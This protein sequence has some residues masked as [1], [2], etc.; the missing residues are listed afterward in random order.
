MLRIGEFNAKFCIFSDD[1]I[2][3][4]L[5]KSFDQNHSHDILKIADF[6]YPSSA[7]SKRILKIQKEG[8]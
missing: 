1:E 7:P 8:R 2:Q 3:N 4:S 5:S 6:S